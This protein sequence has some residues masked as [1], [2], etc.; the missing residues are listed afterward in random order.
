MN[1]NFTYVPGDGIGPEVGEAA[2][3]VLKAMANK[4]GHT[5]EPEFHLIGGA[6]ID[7]L[8]EPLPA[9][10]LLRPVKRRARYCSALWA[11]RNGII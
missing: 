11:G 5:L 6:A 1:I 3:A 9:K 10:R 7:E 4:F 2:M 8:G